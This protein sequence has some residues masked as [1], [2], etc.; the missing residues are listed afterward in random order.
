MD[1]NRLKQS[2]AYYI[3][4]NDFEPTFKISIFVT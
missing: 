3:K 4:Q 2:N 1:Q